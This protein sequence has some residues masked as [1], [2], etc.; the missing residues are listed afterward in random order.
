MIEEAE[1]YKNDDLLI[2]ERI[3]AKNR[4][5][6]EIYNLKNK[7][8]SSNNENEKKQLKNLFD[9]YDDW[10]KMNDDVSKELYETKLSE[11]NEDISKI[12]VN[13]DNNDK[14]SSSIFDDEKYD[15]PKID[16]VD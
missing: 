13:N 12:N 8:S 2:K 14:K 1:K 10:L 9:T 3:E 4:L 7:E 11:L 16:E 15:G 6:G 5:E